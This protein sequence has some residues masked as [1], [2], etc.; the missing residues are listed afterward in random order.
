MEEAENLF[1]SQQKGA[2]FATENYRSMT[3]VLRKEWVD[4]PKLL[5]YIGALSYSRGSS[6]LDLSGYA[7]YMS[8]F[9]A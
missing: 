6:E 5:D 8:R 3:K 1:Y 9:K 7:Y 4:N 2:V